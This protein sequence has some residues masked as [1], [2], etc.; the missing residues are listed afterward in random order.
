M[1]K[2]A[3]ISV[4]EKDGVVEFAKG[5]SELG[6][7]IISTG[8]TYKLLKEEVEV[9]EVGEVTGFREMLGGRVKTLHPLIH[10]GILYRRENE[11]DCE[12]IKEEGIGSIDIVVNNL[13]PF[14]KKLEEGASYE[15]MVENIDIGGPSMIRA[16]AKNHK[17]VLIVVDHNDYA[18]V[19]D[20]L[21]NN[22]VDLEYRKSLAA[23]AFRETAYYDGLI[24]NY[25]SNVLG[26]KFTEKR[27]IPLKKDSILRY[28]ENPVQEAAFYTNGYL[29]KDEKFN[30]VKLHGKEISFNNL[31]DLYGA[32]RV[33]KEFERPTVVAVK[34]TNPC[35]IGSA[36]NINEAFRKCYE[37]DDTSI[38]G[39]IIAINR[40]VNKELAE[41]LH[42]I[43]LEI[44]IAPSFDEDAFEILSQKENIRLL[45]CDNIVEANI[46]KLDIKP[47][48][49]GILIQDKDAIL[50]EEDKL[51][52]VSKRKPT[53][54]EWANMLFGLKA[55]K[56]VSSN[57]VALVK[58][59][60]TIGLGF[61]QVR[62]SWAVES[63]LE[64]AGEKVEGSV[65]A[66]D[67]FF[68]EDTIE[69]LHE[70]GVK[71]VISPGGSKSDPGVIELADKYDMA[72][73][74]TGMRH[75]R[76]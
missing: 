42:K 1:K 76:H 30:L 70:Y 36:D 10:G 67:G 41:E 51:E 34:H 12:T 63:A 29:P 74:F 64:R 62:R 21:K 52:V 53:E 73:V 4:F 35:G 24:S 14:E 7:E 9:L 40:P 15:D 48:L 2:R 38:F 23:K 6:Y 56:Y 13:Y 39:G 54:E 71:A 49:N 44:V 65:L 57:G 69:L 50:Y 60:G 8:G 37:C 58:D 32:V 45:Q 28:G 22:T 61:G 43:F 11:S 3:L 20:R 47:V 26:E 18:E 17:D 59:E 5:L 72:L 31:N 46:Q 75:F 68:F 25:F 66:S 55:V 16:A 27:T 33:L 19:I